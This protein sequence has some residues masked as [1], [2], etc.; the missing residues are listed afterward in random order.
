MTLMTRA[1][2]AS[3][4]IMPG[5]ALNTRNKI[6][7]V[8]RETAAIKPPH[9]R[10]LTRAQFRR[11]TIPTPT[12]MPNAATAINKSHAIPAIVLVPGGIAGR[13]VEVRTSG[14]TSIETSINNPPRTPTA[15][16]MMATTAAAVTAG[17]DARLGSMITCIALPRAGWSRI[18]CRFGGMSKPG[19]PLLATPT[20]RHEHLQPSSFV[21][22]LKFEELPGAGV[23]HF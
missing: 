4:G 12:K 18:A 2:S 6:G 3:F 13:P 15:P 1:A 14:I 8:I 21:S 23:Y 5:M 22:H 11:R 9:T 19:R 7:M 17:R 10:R 16:K 20:S